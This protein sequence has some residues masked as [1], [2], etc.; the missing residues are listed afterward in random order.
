VPNGGVGG[1]RR[2][3]TLRHVHLFQVPVLPLIRLLRP[4]LQFLRIVL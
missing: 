1:T 4:P 3:L 2:D